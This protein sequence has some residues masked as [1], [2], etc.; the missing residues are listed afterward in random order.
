MK[1]KSKQRAQQ[2]M[3]V[4]ER[5]WKELANQ[6]DRIANVIWRVLEIHLGKGVALLMM[7]IC[8]SEVQTIWCG[9]CFR[10]ITFLL[11]P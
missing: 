4:V 11:K 2:W 8:V 5:K 1:E 10:F 3:H 9:T 6:Q 7:G